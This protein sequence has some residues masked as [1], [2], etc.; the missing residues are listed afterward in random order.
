MKPIN[1]MRN[2]SFLLLL[3]M[4]TACSTDTAE[5]INATQN[6]AVQNHGT[7]KTGL[8]SNTV[9]NAANPYDHIGETYLSLL[10]HY[11]SVDPK[12]E[13]S[14]EVM[15]L[16]E[17]IGGNIGFLSSDYTPESLLSIDTV[18]QLSID[19]L[20]LALS[21]SGLSSEAQAL[22]LNCITG[23]LE[24]KEQD[25]AYDEAYACLVSFESSVLASN[26]SSVEKQILLSTLSIVR[27]DIY[28]TSAREK[29]DRDWELSVGNFMATTYGAKQSLPN[30]IISA[31]ISNILH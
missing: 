17:T 25:A 28:N 9:S 8:A 1:K 12:P 21:Q 16:L 6:R 23:L 24:L 4:S 10:D 14:S 27:Y 2:L 15:E 7:K 26:L 19:N 29:K 5:E 13:S 3:L 31:G 30:A 18:Q 22:L 11:E 20:N